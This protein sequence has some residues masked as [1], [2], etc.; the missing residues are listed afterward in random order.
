M[1]MAWRAQV[2]NNSPDETA[3]FRSC[4]NRE[5]TTGSMIMIQPPLMA[6][7]FEARRGAARRGAHAHTR[8]HTHAH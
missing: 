6:Y 2:F 4:L 3:F 8:T 5:G 7:N 1:R